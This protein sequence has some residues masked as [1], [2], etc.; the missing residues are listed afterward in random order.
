MDLYVHTKHKY[1]GLYMYVKMGTM[2]CRHIH[3]IFKPYMYMYPTEISMWA[4]SKA[5]KGTRKPYLATN[6]NQ[7]A[8]K[9]FHRALD[10]KQVGVGWDLTP[11][12]FLLTHEDSLHH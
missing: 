11:T 8:Y 9:L 7:K 3:V 12:V 10:H 1:T 5:A 4:V 2:Y 6:S